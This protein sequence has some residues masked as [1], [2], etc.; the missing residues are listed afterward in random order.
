MKNDWNTM[1]TQLFSMK[2]K[3]FSLKTIIHQS[4][5]AETNQPIGPSKPRNHYA[6]S[7]PR[8]RVL[9]IF[10]SQET[11]PMH[12]FKSG[13]LTYAFS[14]PRKPCLCNPPGQEA[15]PMQ[16]SKPGDH[17]DASFQARKPCLGIYPC[18]VTM[19][20]HPSKR[21]KHSYASF[22]AKGPH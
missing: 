10:P 6:S 18:Q 19:P 15:M 16:P 13:K 9:C 20:M 8:E 5:S 21:G 2:I 4:V 17:A 3:Q 12:P 14:Q 7:Q 1:K 22:Q 11:T